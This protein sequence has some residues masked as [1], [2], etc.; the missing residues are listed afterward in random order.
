MLTLAE[1]AHQIVIER[2]IEAAFARVAL[3]AGAAAELVVDAAGLVALGAEDEETAGGFDFFALVG[4]DLF[5][6]VEAS[7]SCF[8]VLGFSLR[9]VASVLSGADFVLGQELGVAAEQ[10][11]GSAAGHVGGDRDGALAS[12]LGDD[13]GFALVLFGVQDVVLDA[14][15][16]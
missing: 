8:V 16:A 15:A 11:V 9:R 5:P 6:L 13:L 14:F 12:G 1:D 10:D 7:S 3:T 2:E 4:A